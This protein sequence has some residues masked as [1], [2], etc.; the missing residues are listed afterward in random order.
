MNSDCL[1]LIPNIS[2]YPYFSVLHTQVRIILLQRSA[3]ATLLHLIYAAIEVGMT[4]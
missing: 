4:I 2:I 1:R 3:H